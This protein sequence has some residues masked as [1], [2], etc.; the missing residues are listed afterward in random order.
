LPGL[1][2]AKIGQKWLQPACILLLLRADQVVQLFA[3]L[4]VLVFGNGRHI[5]DLQVMI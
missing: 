5:M 2:F 4:I 3:N 1:L